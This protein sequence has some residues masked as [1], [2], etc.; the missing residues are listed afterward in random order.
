MPR[1]TRTGRH[2]QAGV[3]S[4]NEAAARCRGKRPAEVEVVS[5]A[6]RLQ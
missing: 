5:A 4:F 3:T 2:R 6:V 1:K